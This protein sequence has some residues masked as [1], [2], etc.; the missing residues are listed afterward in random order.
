MKKT[1]LQFLFI[2][3]FLACCT[4]YVSA[5][6]SQYGRWS[7][8]GYTGV[9]RF[10]GDID[11]QY[12]TKAIL[13]SP[14]LDF[15]VDYNLSPTFAFGVNIGGLIFNQEDIN[16]SFSSGAV[17]TSTHI[18]IDMLSL[19]NGAK[20]KKWSVLGGVGLGLSGLIQPE[21]ISGRTGGALDPNNNA[22]IFP[23]A[24]Y[25]L[26][27]SGSIEYNVSKRYCLGLTFRMV[28]T[29]T[30][31]IE[32][33]HRHEYRDTWQN[34]SLTLRYKLLSTDNKHFRDEIFER[35]EEPSLKLISKLQEDINR[36]SA[37]IDS[38]DNKTDNLDE[39]LV[40]L[41]GILS[42]DGP[43]TD[44]DGVPDVRDLEP[45]TP[46]GTP[47]DFWGRSLPAKVVKADDLLSVYF[48]FDSIEL[49][50]IAQITLVKVA[51][52]MRNNPS[53]MLEIRG[54][55]DNLGTNTYNQRLSQRR[56]EQVKLQLAKVYGIAQ[57]RMV[58]NGKGK[59]S[60]PP[61][62]TLMNRRCDFFF[63]E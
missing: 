56:A 40:K 7:V 52:R 57:N 63:S 47:V 13:K 30:D 6:A 3:I 39:R 28:Y 1:F 33:S 12:N 62:K 45:N 14:N 2:L 23:P 38:V 35:Q 55:T 37:R 41:E 15:S 54:Y 59:I 53:L 5:G 22:I 27:L 4:A 42:N 48:D 8:V 17:Y 16:E 10:D 50:K 24:F 44:K 31:N 49:D 58:A 36:L 34:L 32:S 25:I 18:T 43:D 61:V 29:N 9:N 21:Y 11:P 26:P 51:E 20:S 19:L 46:P 60:N